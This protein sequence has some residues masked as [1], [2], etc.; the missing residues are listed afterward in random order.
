MITE[1][2][3]LYC[4]GITGSVHLP[5]LQ[6]CGGR[7]C[8]RQAHHEADCGVPGE[9]CKRLSE[10]SIIITV[11]IFRQMHYSG[12][13]EVVR[14]T[15]QEEQSQKVLYFIIFCFHYYYS[16]GFRHEADHLSHRGK[17]LHVHQRPVGVSKPVLYTFIFHLQ[18]YCTPVQ[19]V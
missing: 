8:H 16:E 18:L 13:P 19:W 11:I 6:E 17:T 15:E 4:T 1:S 2:V 10:S 3:H 9:I 7:G 14:I 12:E 5:V